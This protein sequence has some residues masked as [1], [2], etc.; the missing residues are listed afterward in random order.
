MLV[1]FADDGTGNVTTEG[2][3]VS[4]ATTVGGTLGV[5]GATTLSSTLGVTGA[6]TLSSTLGVAG[7]TTV[8]LVLHPQVL[9][10]VL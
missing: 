9:Q 3:G 10:L 6:T 2:T 4:G 5:T 8:T 1:H 7:D